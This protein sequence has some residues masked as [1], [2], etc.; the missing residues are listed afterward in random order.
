N[1]ELTS[2]NVVATIAG[3]KKS[4]EIVSFGA[5]YDSTEFSTG[6]Y[7]NG[8][9]SVMIMEFLKYFAQNPPLRT[10]KF[11]WYG[12]EEIGLEGSKAYTEAHKK[13]LEKHLFMV[14]VDVGAPVLGVN[15][16]KVMASK[17]LTAF[18]DIFMKVKG[19][20]VEVSQG[21]YSSDSVPFADHG[22]PAVNFSRD[23]APGASFI[24]SRGDVME[25]LSEEGLGSLMPPLFDY[26]TA[27]V[28]AP[29]FPEKREIPEEIKT[30]VDKYLFKKECGLLKAQVTIDDE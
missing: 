6:V 28:N 19:Y 20:G 4:E 10:V 16:C 8:A 9:G 12:S 14:N 2:H 11:M 27:L 22:V 23:G 18:T 21:I 15:R 30:E 13:E 3:R 1:V 29:A 17:E 5:H 26:C 7:D 25:Y 24:H